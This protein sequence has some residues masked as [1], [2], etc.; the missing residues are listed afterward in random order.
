MVHLRRV[1]YCSPSHLLVSPVPMAWHIPLGLTENWT[2]SHWS[3]A[4]HVLCA[5]RLSPQL[6]CVEDI[7]IPIL[8]MRKLRL[9]ELTQVFKAKQADGHDF[10]WGLLGFEK[11]VRVV[12]PLKLRTDTALREVFPSCSRNWDHLA[13]DIQSR[14]ALYCCFTCCVCLVPCGDGSCVYDS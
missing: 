9:L 14:I 5:L 4:W 8:Q 11:K 6:P 13:L 3:S 10:N 7:K 2:N 1:N 12:F